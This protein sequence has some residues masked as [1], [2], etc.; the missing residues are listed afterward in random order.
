MSE[1]KSSKARGNQAVA[2]VRSSAT[3]AIEATSDTARD[4]ARQ[5]AEGIEA[6]PVGVL[7]GG[8]ARP[9]LTLV[10][11]GAE[12]GQQ[13]RLQQPVQVHHHKLHLCIIDGPLRGGAPRLFR[14]R[15][16]GKY[17]DDLDRSE[18]VEV[19]STRIGHAAAENEVEFAHEFRSR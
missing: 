6:N 16:I 11:F 19:Q 14:A 10:R 9:G 13:I 15:I 1:A 3:K 4:L 5:T 2:K 8:V 17:T 7:A 18:V 12:P